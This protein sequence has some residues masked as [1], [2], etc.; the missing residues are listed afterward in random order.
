MKFPSLWLAGFVLA[1]ATL[2]GAEPGKGFR[3]CAACADITSDLGILIVG[4]FNPT[5]ATHIH[6][7]R[8]AIDRLEP[9]KIGW[10]S[11]S[12]STHGFNR[13]WFVKSEENRRNPF[14]G[15]DR[16]RMNPPSNKPDEL[17]KPAGPVDPEI[18]TLVEVGTNRVEFEAAPKMVTRLLAMQREM[19]Q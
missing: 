11:G 2:H 15:I 3:A 17:I 7:P 18:E 19:R 8:S 10:G 4:S 12:D 6:A 5:P 16:V 9:A 14:G 1:R 13:R